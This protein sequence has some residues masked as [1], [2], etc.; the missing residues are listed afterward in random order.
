MKC[1]KFLPKN[2]GGGAFVSP[3]YDEKRYVPNNDFDPFSK[4]KK[5]KKGKI[6]PDDGH[7]LCEK[8]EYPI[9]L[10]LT[11][12]S[13]M[14]PLLDTYKNKKE[15]LQSIIHCFDVH[16]KH[17][18]KV[19][20]LICQIES[21][22]ENNSNNPDIYMIRPNFHIHIFVLL[23]ENYPMVDF[24][25]KYREFIPYPY[26]KCTFNDKRYPWRNL[27]YVLKE[28]NRHK[29]YFY[30]DDEMKKN[31]PA[32]LQEN[33]KK[34][35]Q[36]PISKQDIW[37]EYEVHNLPT[38]RAS[39]YWNAIVTLRNWFRINHILIGVNNLPNSLFPFFRIH[40]DGSYEFFD[41]AGI[42]D[43]LRADPK[44][45]YYYSHFREKYQY[46]LGETSEYLNYLDSFIVQ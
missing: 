26:Q 7:P 10:I 1:R 41:G 36:Y 21:K 25:T 46:L 19:K 22:D 14:D 6:D 30:A 11:Y 27:A 31:L 24:E 43:M 16:A 29:P 18:K 15:K 2:Q 4:G 44:F 38:G 28:K 37:S 20:L 42:N 32:F 23:E 17:F 40:A 5:G 3:P 45:R 9:T 39:E 13:D 35:K 8:H 12:H 34:F 33:M